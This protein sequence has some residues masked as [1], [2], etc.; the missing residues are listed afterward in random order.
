LIDGAV[1]RSG[2]YFR[3]IN[4]HSSLGSVAQAIDN[5]QHIPTNQKAIL[6]MGDSRIEEGFSAKIATGEAARAGL[7]Y[8]FANG[9]VGGTTQRV[10]FYLLRQMRP[11][12]ERL[13][14]VVVM[15]TT[16]HDNETEPQSERRSDIAFV[17]P[18][19]T[20]KD[21]A[22][23]PWSFPSGAARLEAAESIMFKGLFYKTDVQDFLRSP[24]KRIRAVT[25]WRQHG[26]EWASAYPGRAPSL[27]GLD[28]DLAT[29]KLSIPP[30]HE[31]IQI[32][33]LAPYADW[34]RWFHGRTPDN[35]AAAAYQ[36]EWLGRIS[37]LCR[38]AGVKLF[39]YRIPRGPLHH[40]VDADDVPTGVLAET[41]R[42][43]TLELLPASLFDPL[44]RPEFFFDALHLNSTGRARFSVMLS[45]TI[46]QHL[47]TAP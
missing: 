41:A 25:A 35:A 24:G 28:L 3:W 16:Y 27:E 17:H 9:S 14:A 15:L 33:T 38:E 11:S 13:A 23:F 12:A 10:W 46:L 2:F 32:A 21:L 1:F 18:L 31:A 26:F 5:I 45:E 7:P 47:S 4:H 6:V 44:E 19:L 22:D 29:G 43:G 8:V 42:A 34:L 40:L 36:R 39:V 30:G 20:L 37:D